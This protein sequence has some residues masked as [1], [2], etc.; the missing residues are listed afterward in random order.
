MG[1]RESGSFY[2]QRALVRRS[3]CSISSTSTAR[4]KPSGAMI[5]E[6][7]ARYVYSASETLYVGDRPEDEAAARNAGVGFQ[8]ADDFFKDA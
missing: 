8:W 6:A 2:C 3:L 7:M 1:T 4:R 5:R